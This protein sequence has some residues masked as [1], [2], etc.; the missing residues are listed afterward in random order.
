MRYDLFASN[1]ELF[2]K[3]REGNP[4]YDVIFPTNDFVER[5]IAAE[6][7]L[8]LDHA[9]I[10][11]LKNIDPLFADAI[12]DPGRTLQRA[13]LLGHD[14]HR[15]S[16]LRGGAD[17]LGRPVRGRHLCRAHRVAELARHDPGGA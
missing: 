16:G 9:L 10:P 2:A 8:P 12:Y 15:L 5:M 11:N 14:R 7:L 3:L 6:M 17:Q 4:G 13:L 1:E